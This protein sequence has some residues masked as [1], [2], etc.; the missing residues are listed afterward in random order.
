MT[1]GPPYVSVF[2]TN[3]LFLSIMPG[4]KV[5]LSVAIRSNISLGHFR[6]FRIPV[7]VRRRPRPLFDYEIR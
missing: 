7:S 3:V 1:V 6:H 2:P 5:S 4:R